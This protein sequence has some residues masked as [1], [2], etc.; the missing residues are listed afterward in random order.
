M[1][2]NRL[3]NPRRLLC[4]VENSMIMSEDFFFSDFAKSPSAKFYC[5]TDDFFGL[6]FN[7]FSF[8]GFPT[9]SPWK[10]SPFNA[11]SICAVC[12]I[13][14]FFSPSTPGA[15]STIN[16]CVFCAFEGFTCGRTSFCL[17]Q[18]MHDL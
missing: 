9:D 3:V 7:S 12:N 15:I 13:A 18:Y 4:I 17:S 1:R 5:R 2:K 10:Q 16:G 14:H 11:D 6:F 8:Y